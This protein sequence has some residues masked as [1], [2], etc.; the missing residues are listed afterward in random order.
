MRDTRKVLYLG[1]VVE[2]G[3]KSSLR[4]N[5]FWLDTTSIQGKSLLVFSWNN[6]VGLLVWIELSQTFWEYVTLRSSV[7]SLYEDSMK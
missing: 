6:V 3:R 2:H 5:L 4:K 7:V 1:K